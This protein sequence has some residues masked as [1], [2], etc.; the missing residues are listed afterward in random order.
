MKGDSIPKADQTKVRVLVAD[1][2]PVV[3][4]GINANVKPQR[5]M[6]VIAEADDG[7]EALALIK[8]QVPDVVFEV[9]PIV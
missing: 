8:E 1:D 5:D 3:R 4:H 6:T 2:H 7:V 9:L